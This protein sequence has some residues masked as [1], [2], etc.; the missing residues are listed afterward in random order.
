MQ[1]GGGGEAIGQDIVLYTAAPHCG[2]CIAAAAMYTL[3]RPQ[4]AAVDCRCSHKNGANRLLLCDPHLESENLA[5]ATSYQIWIQARYY[6]T[7]E[8]SFKKVVEPELNE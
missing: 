3:R 6:W 8:L 5:L 2:T 1:V 7:G 4:H